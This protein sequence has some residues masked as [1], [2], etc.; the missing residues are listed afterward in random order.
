MSTLNILSRFLRDLYY[1]SCESFQT[2]K[3]V[4]LLKRQLQFRV[5]WDSQ[6]EDRVM[7]WWHCLH[8][9]N[10]IHDTADTACVISNLSTKPQPR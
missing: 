2:S 5:W 7:D 8:M 1:K 4:L 10:W 3:I 9:E 6:S